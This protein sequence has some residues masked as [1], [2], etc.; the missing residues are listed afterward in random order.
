MS[1]PVFW[2]L[3]DFT[4]LGLPDEAINKATNQLTEIMEAFAI[5]VFDPCAVVAVPVMYESDGGS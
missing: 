1:G 2:G 4:P 5:V 3:T